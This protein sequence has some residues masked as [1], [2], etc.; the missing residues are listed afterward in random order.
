[1]ALLPYVQ[2]LDVPVPQLVNQQVEVLQKIDTLIP[3]QVI[4]V[5][6]IPQDRI[7]QRSVEFRPPQKAELLVELPTVV[8]YSSLKRLA[9]QN[10]HF[11]APRTHGDQGG[12]Q[13]FHP[14]P[15]SAQRTVEQIVHIPV[16][17]GL[18]GFGFASLVSPFFTFKIM[19]MFG[20]GLSWRL[21]W[22]SLGLEMEAFHRCAL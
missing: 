4:E 5:P 13:G 18:Q 20:F 14:G 12:L 22:G 9:A 2:I 17:G 1:M 10:V 16:V 15:G 8:S 19:L 3:P 11:P 6:Q 7:P 21:V